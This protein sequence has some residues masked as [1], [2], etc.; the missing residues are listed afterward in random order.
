MAYLM[1][2]NYPLELLRQPAVEAYYLMAEKAYHQAFDLFKRK[3][4][5]G[6]AKV[7]CKLK[8]V[9]GAVLLYQVTDGSLD[10]THTAYKNTA[11]LSK[12]V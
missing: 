1:G 3:A 2:H 10:E 5:D 9:T 7:I 6:N 11:P 12:V 4:N 8:R